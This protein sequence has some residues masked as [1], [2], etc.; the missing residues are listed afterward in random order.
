MVL[1]GRGKNQKAQATV[2]STDSA[3]GRKRRE[4]AYG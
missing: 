2:K 1:S 4:H 3:S